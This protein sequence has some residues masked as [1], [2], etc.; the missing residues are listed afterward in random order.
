MFNLVYQQIMSSKY[1][2]KLV[3]ASIDWKLT[4]KPQPQKMST[5]KIHKL[6]IN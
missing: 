2:T 4:W 1:T 6:K 5:I 3:N